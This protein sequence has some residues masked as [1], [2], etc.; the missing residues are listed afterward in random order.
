MFDSNRV[1]MY[2][3]LIVILL[4]C[5]F[6]MM[7]AKESYG[8]IYS[9][10]PVSLPHPLNHIKKCCMKNGCYKKN[11]CDKRGNNMLGK[12]NMCGCGRS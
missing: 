4:M 1:S 8:N 12:E 9:N 6:I 10:Y 11:C 7:Y 2:L 3:I 5:G